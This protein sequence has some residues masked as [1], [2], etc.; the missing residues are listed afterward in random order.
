MRLSELETLAREGRARLEQLRRDFVRMAAFAMPA[1][2]PAAAAET[3]ERL[4]ACLLYTSVNRGLFRRCNRVAVIARVISES[5]KDN[6][7]QGFF[8]A[9]TSYYH[10]TRRRQLEAA[11][12]IAVKS[13]ALSDAPPIRPPST[14]GCLSSSAAFFAFMEPPYWMVRP[15]AAVRS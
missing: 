4:D 9:G 5:V 2:D 1:L 12:T 10:S 15:S 14:S 13:A 3:A 11:L 7:R 6:E 8:H